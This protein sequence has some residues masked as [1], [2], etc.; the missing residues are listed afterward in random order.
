MYKYIRHTVICKIVRSIKFLCK[1]GYSIVGEREVFMKRKKF[2]WRKLTSLGTCAVTA[3]SF[4]FGLGLSDISLGKAEESDSAD[5]N[6]SQ[7]F[8]G[9]GY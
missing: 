9:G 6:Y 5:S 4:A 3:L 1:C 7:N 8:E 2:G